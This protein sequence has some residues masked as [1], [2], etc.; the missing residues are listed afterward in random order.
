MTS[1]TKE[2]VEYLERIFPNC[3]PEQTDTNRAV[4]VAVGQVNVV[5]HIRGLFNRAVEK[6]LERK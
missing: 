1:F 6:E 2:Q 5:K 4:W 3:V